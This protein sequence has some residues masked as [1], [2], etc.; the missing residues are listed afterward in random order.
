MTEQSRFQ[1]VKKVAGLLRISTE[2]TDFQGKKSDLEETLR[3]HEE[4]MVAYIE[5]QGWEYKLFK[6]VLS[7]GTLYEKREDLVELMDT[8]EEY[9]A[10][11]VIELQRLS[12][13]GEV[14]QRIKTKV[15]ANGT[16]I[17]T[18]TPMQVLDIARNTMDGLVYDF[19]SAVA[20]YER[21]VASSRV[22][23]N[24]MSMARQG[25]NSSGSVPF[26]YKRNPSTKKL[27]IVEDQAQVVK[28]I[29]NWYFDG[30]GFKRIADQLNEMGIKNNKNN[31]W[32][33]NSIKTLIS[34]PTYKGTLIARNYEMEK[35]KRVVTETVTVHNNHPAI[36]SPE[37]FERAQNLRETKRKR[38]ETVSSKGQATAHDWNAKKHV[39]I[40]DGLVWC[41][42]CGRKSTIKFMHQKG[43]NP[44]FYIRKCS[45]ENANGDICTNSGSSIKP[46]EHAVFQ[47]ILKEQIRL[48][49]NLNKFENNDFTDRNQELKDQ[50]EILEKQLKKALVEME[51]ITDDIK[52][53]KVEKKMTGVEDK[54]QEESLEKQKKDNQEKRMNLRKQLDE[55]DEKLASIPTVDV[56]IKQMKEKINIIKK[57]RSGSNNE[58]FDVNQVNLL[59]QQLILRINYKRETPTGYR[60][61]NKEEVDQ[62]PA[63]IEIEYV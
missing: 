46:I 55:I 36:I 19:G 61:R 7:G 57:L 28:M 14:S 53:Y 50:K 39:S 4:K 3:N 41:G 37:I 24:K 31:K 11:V 45:K 25:L 52:E 21:R 8:L 2:K 1:K 58:E 12:R 42:C 29:F 15:I 60:A 17:I 33:P 56:E 51:I 54:D 43:R 10:I 34:R 27:E 32:I 18:L 9:D 30:I 22:K 6:E 13:Q 5:N 23:Q 35:G 62:Y 49:E 16:L 40:L 63:Q 20:E 44:N 47:D 26:G 48:E 59:F 38:A